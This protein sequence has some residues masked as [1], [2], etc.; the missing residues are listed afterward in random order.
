MESSTSFIVRVEAGPVGV[1]PSGYQ[2]L[3]GRDFGGEAGALAVNDDWA[4]TIYRYHP[5]YAPTVPS[6]PKP[7]GAADEVIVSSR[8]EFLDVFDDATYTKVFIVKGTDLYNGQEQLSLTVSGSA[9]APRWFI[10]YD[11]SDPGRVDDIRPWDLDV[12][13]KVL[14]P[15][16]IYAEGISHTWFVGLQWGIWA[17]DPLQYGSAVLPYGTKFGANGG[18]SQSAVWARAGAHDLTFYRCYGEYT[19]NTS[20]GVFSMMYA[21]SDCGDRLTWYECF[22][23]KPYEYEQESDWILIQNGDDHRVV[24]C[25][26][27]DVNNAAIQ[28][29]DQW[30]GK[31]F[32]IENCDFYKER[33]YDVD[34]NEQPGGPYVQGDSLSGTKQTGN[35]SLP[36]NVRWYGNR[37]WGTRHACPGLDDNPYLACPIVHSGAQMSNPQCFR[38]DIRWNIIIDC[39]SNNIRMFAQGV[40]DFGDADTGNHT[41]A[42]N[43][44]AM[45]YP[46]AGDD[47]D[48]TWAINEDNVEV[49]LNTV[50][51][52]S[53]MTG[54]LSTWHAAGLV[55]DNFDVMGNFFM[56][57][58]AFSMLI[59]NNP[60]RCSD[61]RVGYNAFAGT[62]EVYSRTYP[63]GYEHGADKSSLN[64]GDF[65]FRRKQLS[66]P[67]DPEW[68][69]TIPGI[70]PTSS[71]PA[72]FLNLVP[73]SGS[74]AIGSRSGIGSEAWP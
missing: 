54:V 20:S 36:V 61:W 11:P 39:Y 46:A 8:Q 22:F 17:P 35:N 14:M 72:E 49:H 51:Y 32:V 68:L 29:G 28:L 59:E 7:T 19:A 16:R 67:N 73:Q 2:D 21:M 18:R 64:M 40:W 50:A 33:R 45:S 3:S 44:C 13:E 10:W 6:L 38:N 69:T 24:N 31:E 58:G 48:Y 55:T 12:S 34:G 60:E 47:T 74:D 27:A 56:D 66:R 42:R 25:E 52:T 23:A 71:T 65:T 5:R 26:F 4:E 37:F 41:I 1:S 62:Y 15:H 53:Q 43:I 9:G 57:T 63:V 70:V 30:G